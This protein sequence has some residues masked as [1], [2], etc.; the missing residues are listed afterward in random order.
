MSNK[1][2]SS[3][4]F[5]DEIERFYFFSFLVVLDA[6]KSFGRVIERF[7][8]LDS[9]VAPRHYS[10]RI[11]A[12]QTWFSVGPWPIFK[13]LLILC[14]RSIASVYWPHVST[15]ISFLREFARHASPAIFHVCSAFARSNFFSLIITVYESYLGKLWF[16]KTLSFAQLGSGIMFHHQPL[17]LLVFHASALVYLGENHVRILY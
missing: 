4:T 6:V 13:T 14:Y 17:S 2:Q 15:Q 10:R 12:S 8:V 3:F 9:K 7:P 1:F 11:I 5:S 16:E